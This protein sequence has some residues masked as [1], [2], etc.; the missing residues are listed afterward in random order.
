M[1]RDVDSEES[2]LEVTA[3]VEGDR[4]AAARL[5]ERR[6]SLVRG[7]V[8]R[9]RQL[10]PSHW[11]LLRRQGVVLLCGNAAHATKCPTAPSARVCVCVERLPPGEPGQ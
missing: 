7:H 11:I 6:E 3:V 10:A 2:S 9:G 8:E 5:E 4:V 1:P